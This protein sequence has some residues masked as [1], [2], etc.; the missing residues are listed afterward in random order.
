MLEYGG[1]QPAAR[2]PTDLNALAE[3]YLRLTYHDIRAKHRHFNAALLPRLDAAVGTVDVVRHDLGRVLISLFS[4][5]FYAVQ[6]R[7]QLADGA[8][9]DE[10]DEYVPQVMLL[11]E[12]TGP[13]EIRIRVRDNGLG[14]PAEAQSHLFER[15]F[16]TKPADEGPGLG[17]AVSH[18]IVRGLG[19]TLTVETEPG[20]FT[21]LVVTLPAP[22]V[23]ALPV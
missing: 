2:Q 10:A 1:S 7:R 4:N 15:F 13:Q 22:V 17:L 8:A 12:R 11:T 19:G 23:A 14:I 20:A 5:A 6:Q 3:D 21:E 16:S 9:E 18:D